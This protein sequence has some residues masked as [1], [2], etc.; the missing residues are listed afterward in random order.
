MNPH[1]PKFDFVVPRPLSPCCSLSISLFGS[2]APWSRPFFVASPCYLFGVVSLYPCD[3]AFR[4]SQPQ[5]ERG[6]IF[7]Y[8]RLQWNQG[9]SQQH[10]CVHRVFRR[11]IE[12]V[13]W[14][15]G[16]GRHCLH[17]GFLKFALMVEFLSQLYS[18]ISTLV[19]DRW[20]GHDRTRRV[21]KGWN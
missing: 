10:S 8:F 6:E 20:V 19:I 5:L 17:S 14:G 11:K 1:A 4:P 7:N 16:G 3:F 13:A 18:L 2:P 15:R 12:P 21:D 9:H